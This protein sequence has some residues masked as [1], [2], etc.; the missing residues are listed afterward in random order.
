M[1]RQRV[2]GGNTNQATGAWTAESTSSLA[3]CGALKHVAPEQLKSIEGGQFKESVK[4]LIS[5]TDCDIQLNDIIEVYE[6]VG[7]SSKTYWRVTEKI[8]T[9]TTADT[10]R[11]YG[12]NYWKLTL[13]DR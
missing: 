13:E 9:L 3:I 2:T 10:L 11:G 1:N 12:M 8:K 6:D 4:Q 5:H 7:G